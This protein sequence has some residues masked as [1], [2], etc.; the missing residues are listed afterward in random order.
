MIFELPAW[1]VLASVLAALLTLIW[2]WR[3]E[4]RRVLLV[5]LPPALWL[6]VLYAGI[7]F[8]WFP[9]SSTPSAAG[10]FIRFTFCMIFL[11]QA[12]VDFMTAR[13]IVALKGSVLNGR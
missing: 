6:A 1:A 2:R 10:A 4:R 9:T 7:T 12:F 13:E 8:H 11:S 5:K 3:V